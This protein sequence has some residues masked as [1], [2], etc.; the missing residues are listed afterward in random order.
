MTTRAAL[1]EEGRIASKGNVSLYSERM[2][3]DR[4][5]GR[6][7]LRNLEICVCVCMEEEGA[8]IVG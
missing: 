4:S 7:F 6:I 3:G 8:S 2:K 5:R 1:L